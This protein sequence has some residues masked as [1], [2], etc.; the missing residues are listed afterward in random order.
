ML[1]VK[2]VVMLKAK[3]VVMLKAKSGIFKR[4]GRISRLKYSIFCSYTNQIR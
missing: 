1:R 2:S 4:G 3:S